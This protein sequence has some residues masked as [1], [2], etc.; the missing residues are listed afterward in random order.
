MVKDHERV[1]IKYLQEQEGSVLPLRA[2]AQKA[3]LTKMKITKV[4]FGKSDGNKKSGPKKIRFHQDE[5]SL[6][7]SM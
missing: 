7:S 2:V 5:K 3:I 6:Q 1:V 4:K